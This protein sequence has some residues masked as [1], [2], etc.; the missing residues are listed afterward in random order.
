MTIPN[1]YHFIY[2]LRR[3]TE[4]F[5][6]LHYLCLESCIRVNRPES[7]RMYYHYE[8]YGPY[9]DLIRPRSTLCACH[10]TAP[11]PSIGVCVRAALA[12]GI[13]T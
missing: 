8:P 9:G 4:P 1:R 3:Q 13:G 5:Q 10:S 7:I 6:L 2:G 12:G 11:F